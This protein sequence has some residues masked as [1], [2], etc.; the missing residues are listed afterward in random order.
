MKKLA[1]LFFIMLASLNAWANQ[2]DQEIQKIYD[3]LPNARADD[4]L[5]RLTVIS[6]YFKGRPYVLGNLGEG[7]QGKYDQEPLYRTD[8]FDC[9]TYVE[10]VI[11]LAKANK[12]LSR[13]GAAIAG[14]NR[15]LKAAAIGWAESDSA[16][17][18]ALKRSHFRKRCLR[19]PIATPPRCRKAL[20][21]LPPHR[22]QR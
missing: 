6:E 18:S 4:L 11:A 15:D 20:L 7:S 21:P 14:A 19:G 1:L 5:T 22:E 9:T 16:L 2:H 8:V 10:T 3:K 12:S 17:R 13:F